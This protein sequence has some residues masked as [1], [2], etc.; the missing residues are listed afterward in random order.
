MTLLLALFAYRGGGNS[1]L[2]E[3]ILI[4]A[5]S[6]LILAFLVWM[7]ME[8]DMTSRND[9]QE[10]RP[11]LSIAGIIEVLKFPIVWLMAIIIM[12]AYSGYWGA[13]FITPYA[14][15]VFELGSVLGGAVGTAKLWIAALAAV[16][17]GVIADKIGPAKAVLGSFILM[18]FGFLVFALLPGAPSLLPLLLVNVT[19]IS[20][21]VYALRGIY[22]SLLEQGGIPLHITGTA[23]GIISVIGFTPDVFMPIL[24][25]MTLD[26][27]PGPDGYQNYFLFVSGISFIGLIAS[28]VVYRKV[29]SKPVAQGNGVN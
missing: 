6:A 3:M 12:A 14:T 29:Q 24:G 15:E 13:A 21:A 8:D 10:A 20:C 25:G 18:T 22:F 16:V 11:I 17:A 19:V 7:V 4:Y 9:S 27:N 1:A 26:A 28:F 2:S 23:T 5:V